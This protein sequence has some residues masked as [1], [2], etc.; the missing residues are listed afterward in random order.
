MKPSRTL[1]FLLRSRPALRFI[2][3]RILHIDD[4]PHRIA[5][6]LA[7]GVFIAF[8]PLMGIQMAIAFVAAAAMK[9]NKAMAMLGVWLSN[10][11]TAIPVYYPCY[12]LGRWIIKIVAERNVDVDIQQLEK[13]LADTLSFHRLLIDFDNPV[14]WKELSA[15]LLKIGLELTIGGVIIGYLV[16]RITYIL[17][18]KIVI[19]HRQRRQNRKQP[20]LL[21]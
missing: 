15:C 12:R 21:N 14:F 20:S 4:S 5:K 9:A 19:F 10:P 16:A 13:L 7:I 3:F 6:G 18:K 11:F 17:T 8:L 2:K 1:K